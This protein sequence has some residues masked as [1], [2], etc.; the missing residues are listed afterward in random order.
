[1]VDS[2][3][4]YSLTSN[5]ITRT[6]IARCIRAMLFVR[7]SPKAASLSDTRA[8]TLGLGLDAK[9]QFGISTS[10]RYASEVQFSFRNLFFEV[11]RGYLVQ[12]Q[13]ETK[14]FTFAGQ[15]RIRNC[16]GGKTET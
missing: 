13:S 16:M 4:T 6:S 2:A 11:L 5:A 12:R 7:C 8:K 3:H 14:I 10:T 1:M 9:W 15:N